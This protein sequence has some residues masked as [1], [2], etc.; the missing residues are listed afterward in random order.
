MSDLVVVPRSDSRLGI[1]RRLL[2]LAAVGYARRLARRKPDVL[3]R[4][5]RRISRAARPARAEEAIAAHRAVVSVSTRCSGRWCLD[6]SIAIALLLRMSGAWPEWHMGVCLLPF[7]AHAWVTVDG[8][9]EGLRDNFKPLMTVV[10]G[11]KNRGL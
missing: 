2:A 4:R 7:R 9:P 10:A 8:E 1:R 5:L 6:R 3:E 11:G